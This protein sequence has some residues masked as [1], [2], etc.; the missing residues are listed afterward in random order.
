LKISMLEKP[1]IT[2]DSI[3]TKN[4]EA[5]EMVL[6]G[7]YFNGQGPEANG[8]AV[9]F[10]KKAID[11]DQNY[12]D[13]YVGLG[14]A[15]FFVGTNNQI[16]EAVEKAL[17]LNEN[18]ESAHELLYGL[19]VREWNWAKA[20]AEYNKF[21]R[22]YSHGYITRAYHLA[23]LG[24]IEQ[25]IHEMKEVVKLD[26]LN[27]NGLR[28][29]ADMYTYNHQYTNARQIL[30]NLLEIDSLYAPAYKSMGNS[31]LN[32]R[33]FELAIENYKREIELSQVKAE[34]QLDLITAI[35]AS[36]KKDE[37]KRLF[38]LVIKDAPEK[39]LSAWRIVPCYFALGEKDAAF[40]RLNEE[41]Q[42]KD[43]RWRVFLYLKIDP[44]FDPY[45]SDSRFK[46]V[47]KKMNLP[48]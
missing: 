29:F 36:G 8:K 6:K 25:A 20:E 47:I 18:S 21:L 16:R 41:Y 7:N 39:N 23:L 43:R 35:A 46:E 13:A 48:E 42:E 38:N 3:P 31:Y 30:Q 34:A 14:W 40:K 32:E 45:R 33:N 1:G 26:P 2:S 44:F 22:S 17:S 11:L 5:Y 28:I 15:Y 24:N 4:M 27:L 12:A 9:G 19:Y 37:A 10:F